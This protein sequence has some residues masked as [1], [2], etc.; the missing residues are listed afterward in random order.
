MKELIG[1]LTETYGPSGN[2]EL[3]RE[4]IKKEIEGFV[5]E[6]KIDVLGNLIAKRG[7]GGAKVMLAAHMD[8]I[9][10]VITHIDEKGFLRF[11]GVG[12]VFPINVLGQR[13]IFANQVIGAFGEEKRESMK[14]ELKFN[15]MYIDVGAKDREEALK[16]VKVGDVA[17]FHRE[18][19]DLGQRLMAKAFDDRIGCAVLIQVL[20]TLKS[21]PNETY[22]VFTV[23]EEVGTR[24]AVTSAYGIAPD[25]GIA[26]DVTGT[27]DTPEAHIMPVEL[28]KG[29]AIKIKD[30]GI[31]A[32]PKVK[33]LMINVAE[34]ENI[35]YQ[36][37]VLER[38][39]TDA[40]AIHTT[41]EGVPSGAISIPTRYIHTPSEMVDLSDVTNAVKLLEKILEEDLKGWGF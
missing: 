35:P 2:E 18:F 40:M 28:G 9:G 37:E 12:G 5:D 1:R 22:F 10:I 27:G 21:S 23:Q 20:K 19:A 32:H 38:G 34:R 15:K 41:R 39:A 24:G 4:T 16:L 3:I 30:W 17:A 26:I 13:V 6:L 14:E 25:I 7:G 29:V 33:S 36:L 31:L 8:E 11:S